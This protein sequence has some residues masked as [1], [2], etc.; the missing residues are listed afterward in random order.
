M[1]P[2]FNLFF[3]PYV[4]WGS[5]KTSLQAITKPS[6]SKKHQENLFDLCLTDFEIFHNV[7]KKLRYKFPV[8]GKFSTKVFVQIAN[9]ILEQLEYF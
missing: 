6:A 4:I 9:R 3:W 5:T 1:R 8:L 2:F 7:V